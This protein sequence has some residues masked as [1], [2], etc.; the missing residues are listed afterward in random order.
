MQN[1]KRAISFM[2]LPFF[3]FPS[4]SSAQLQQH[5]I[6]TVTEVMN[7]FGFGQSAVT[8][9]ENYLTQFLTVFNQLVQLVLSAQ[10]AA[11][12]GSKAITTSEEV[13][14]RDLAVGETGEDVRQL[15]ILL[16]SDK[17]TQITPTGAGSPGNETDYFGE[18]TQ[19]A[20]IAF[21]EKHVEKLPGKDTTDNAGEV[22]PNTRELLNT[23]NTTT[24]PASY[25][26]P[27]NTATNGSHTNTS[28][29]QQ[30]ESNS[31][32][33][34]TTTEPS[35][36][37]NTRSQETA[38]TSQTSNTDTT[39]ESNPP[40]DQTQTDEEAETALE[41]SDTP[42]EAVPP[43][44]SAETE[45]SDVTYILEASFETDLQG[46]H[47]DEGY[48]RSSDTASDGI[49]SIK[50][51]NMG[52]RNFY[53]TSPLSSLQNTTYTLSFDYKITNNPNNDELMFIAAKGSDIWSGDH[54]ALAR[55][56][57]TNDDWLSE[58]TSFNTGSE[59]SII[60]RVIGGSSNQTTYFDNIKISVG[61]TADTSP[62]SVPDEPEEDTGTPHPV[63]D[64]DEP[65]TTTPDPAPSPTQLY[66]ADATL[67]RMCQEQANFYAWLDGERGLIGEFGVPREADSDKY[68]SAVS[69]FFELA[70]AYRFDTTPWALSS[71]W[72]SNYEV[73]PF[74]WSNNSL[75]D[76]AISQPFKD[77]L[78][79]SEYIRGMNLVGG[80]FALGSNGD[81][82]IG[83]I[84]TWT[85][86]Y[87]HDSAIWQEMKNKGITHARFPFR[88]ERLFDDQGT[89]DQTDKSYFEMAMSKAHQAGIS[90]ILDPHNYAAMRI[91]ETNQILGQGLFTE[92]LYYTMM[93]NLAQLAIDEPAITGIGL[94]NEP[95]NVTKDAWES[96]SQGAVDAI[97]ARGFTGVIYVPTWN[98]QG[99]QDVTAHASPW[100][101]D[102][103]DNIV[104]EVHQYIDH[105]HSG[106][107]SNTY[108]SDDS[109]TA[110]AGFSAGTCAIS[111]Q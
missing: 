11:K 84:N 68:R 12:E 59:T 73:Q 43:E 77:N 56:S 99:I 82:I 61:E 8:K 2:L 96:F 79:T 29:T 21:Q 58:S 49:Y 35:Q 1:K 76:N 34:N 72:A 14:Q 33:Q 102:P 45:T 53:M 55:V 89:F 108:A 80:E 78:T 66:A 98:W 42:E 111:I 23:N 3:L 30:V 81:G 71:W 48:S 32:Q 6:D 39:T 103:A 7:I 46:W 40:S 86:T 4:I 16:N 67:M 51:T 47:A 62:E 44:P 38:P 50:A 85:Y 65:V 57:G 36:N 92:S 10:K 107:Y 101:V 88:L 87:H 54:L 60:L 63:D 15:Q 110:S 41:T 27:S 93:S 19:N 90:V 70:N 17:D 64:P 95:K 74:N 75:I 100:I 94:M 91:N 28:S 5:H 37:D 104:Y 18:R 20:V 13:F 105:N 9:V 31:S 52:W 26:T 22:G 83:S 106:A 69:F 24:M 97:R 25:P 109:A